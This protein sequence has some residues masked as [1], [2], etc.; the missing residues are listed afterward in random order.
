MSKSEPQRSESATAKKSYTQREDS[1]TLFYDAPGA[2]TLAGE[3]RCGKTHTVTAEPA[4]D[5]NQRDYIKVSG[6]GVSGGL[7]VNDR[8][9]KETHP[10]YTGPVEFNGRKMRMSAWK[11]PLK[12]GQNAGQDFLSI[13][14]S[15]P[16]QKPQD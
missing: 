12:S 11:K 16:Y 5:K 6:D 9:E 8:K 2:P 15:E 7:F 13:A 3:I 10:D 1:G 4:I 14:V